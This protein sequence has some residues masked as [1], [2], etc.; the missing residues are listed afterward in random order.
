MTSIRCVPRS[1]PLPPNSDALGEPG[2]EG[3]R[4]GRQPLEH[5][6]AMLAAAVIQRQ[7][8]LGADSCEV[9]EGCGENDREHLRDN[10]GIKLQR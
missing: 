1:D 5:L 8:R 4:D 2:E 9:S 6:I 10:G 7:L 3:A